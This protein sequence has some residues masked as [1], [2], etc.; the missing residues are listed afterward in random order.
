MIISA[1]R[2]TV[3][4]IRHAALD[5]KYGTKT[6]QRQTT[7]KYVVTGRQSFTC[8]R[9]TFISRRRQELLFIIQYS[10]NNVIFVHNMTVL[11]K[12]WYNDTMIVIYDLERQPPLVPA[13]QTQRIRRRS[14]VCTVTA[15]QLW[16]LP[17][18]KWKITSIV[19]FKKSLKTH[20]CNIYINHLFVTVLKM[21]Q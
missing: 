5:D 16:N 7:E 19:T 18:T 2:N 8:V 9:P 3:P 21:V 10:L 17:P 15:P 13:I 12:Q 4:R 1:T 20:L 14:F 11:H 6:R